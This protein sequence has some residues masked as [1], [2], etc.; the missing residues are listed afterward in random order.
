M[1]NQKENRL[2]P[3]ELADI[4][5]EGIDKYCQNYTL[6]PVQEKAILDICNCRSKEAGGHIQHCDHCGY[7]QQSYNSCRNRHCPKCQYVKQEQWIDKLTNNLIPGKYFHLVFT[8]PK[9]LHALF[10]INQRIC[11][12]ILF[13]ASSQALQRAGSNPKFL[14]A[15]TGALAVLHTWTKTL[16]YHPH[17]HMLVPAGGLSDDGMEWKSARSKFF[18]PVKVLSRIF[19]GVL[20][21]FIKSSLN[22]GEL[23]LP[24]K[25]FC[26]DK[27]KGH[28]YQKDWNVYLKKSLGGINS[29]LKYLGRY[30]HRVA[31]SNSRLIS[32]AG[33]K[34]SFW[35]KDN[36]AKGKRKIMTLDSNEFI[37]RFLQHILP[38]NF[39]KI[40]YV[41][42][43][44]MANSKTKKEQCLSLIETQMYLPVMVGLNAMEILGILIRKDPFSCPNCQQGIMRVKARKPG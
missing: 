17:I 23:K 31:I 2:Y 6:C 43:L 44:A 3:L 13:K 32:L 33:E 39:Y 16:C 40:R 14:G 35:Y 34:V 8:I 38:D 19:R 9:E 27:L 41:G 10:Y 37:R 5:R 25:N 7:L 22:K 18:L 29:V 24:E 30:T 15:Q 21:M 4:L 1:V 26:F 12:D 36:K 42:L 28:L 20:A 11:Y